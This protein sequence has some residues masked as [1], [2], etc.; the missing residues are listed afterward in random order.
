LG[1]ETSEG[2]E[3]EMKALMAKDAL[4]SNIPTTTS[5]LLKQLRMQK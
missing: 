3:E 4:L 1:N 2:F 5:Y